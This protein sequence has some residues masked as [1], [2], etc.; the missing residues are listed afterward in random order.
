MKRKYRKKR[1]NLALIAVVAAMLPAG[2]L[3]TTNRSATDGEATTASVELAPPEGGR[4][5][6]A[7]GD[8]GLA[9]VEV[10]DEDE[11]L[12]AE[13]QAELQAELE[14]EA[15]EP[16]LAPP[17]QAA[18][19]VTPSPEEAEALAAEER[20][21]LTLRSIAA[22]QRT[23]QAS[24][25]IDTNDDRIGEFGYLAELAGVAPLRTAGTRGPAH[26]APGAFM[27]VPILPRSFGDMQPTS[28][29]G[30]V[31][32]DGYLF[33][34][35]L[36]GARRVNGRVEGLSEAAHGGASDVLPDADQGA[37]RWCAYAWPV[38]EAN[39]ARRAFFLDERGTVLS[40][41]NDGSAARRYAGHTRAPR[42]S[43]AYAKSD[44]AGAHGT[45]KG[46]DGNAWT[47]SL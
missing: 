12:E 17:P 46:S 10:L 9:E 39:P 37:L 30:A 18:E 22:A 1:P 7:I 14:A 6:V 11:Q 21:T 5:E 15:L 23:A 40:T 20:A 33:A 47:R 4:V 24:G 44:M 13:L 19:P 41:P 27:R 28:Q 16:E 34:V 38:S 8:E 29:G 45:A 42:W 3:L 31:E 32:I 43:A 26:G 36:S 25:A 2:F 35:H